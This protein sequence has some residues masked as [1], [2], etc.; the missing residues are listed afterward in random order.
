MRSSSSTYDLESMVNNA[1]CHELLSVVTAIHHEGV[2]ETFDDRAICLSESLLC[3][4]TSGVG[5]VDWGSDLNIIASSVSN[6][7]NPFISNFM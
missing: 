3:I 4:A 5:D 6:V 1:N 2:G 7:L